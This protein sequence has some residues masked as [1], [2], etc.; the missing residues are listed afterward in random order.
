VAKPPNIRIPGLR[1]GQGVPTGYLVGRVSSGHGPAEL[2]SVQQLARLGVKSSKN[3]SNALGNQA[4]FTFSISGVVP[5]NTLIGVGSWS[6]A[7]TF[8]N[9]D[10]N[11][12]GVAIS[13]PAS[14]Y[15]FRMLDNTLAQVGFID[16]TT[17]GVWSVVWTSD[18]LSWAAGTP[19]QVWT[20]VAPDGALAGVNARVVG[21]F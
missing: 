6:K 1:R 8:H 14:D 11:N 9:G 16:V 2:I 15:R 13:N 12:S 17:A 10:T 4:G 19:M 20:Q 18:P 5:A 7:L 3:G 21:Y